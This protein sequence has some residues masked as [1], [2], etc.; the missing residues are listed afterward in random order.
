[1]SANILHIS[2]QLTKCP[3]YIYMGSLPFEFMFL[4]ISP[5]TFLVI[6]L[7]SFFSS[8]YSSVLCLS[9]RCICYHLACYKLAFSV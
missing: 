1:M 9:V 5:Q 7:L 3:R 6:T 2:F 8:L 4:L